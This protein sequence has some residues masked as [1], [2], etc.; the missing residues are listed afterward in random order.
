MKQRH[1]RHF[2]EQNN[3]KSS[4]ALENQQA[5]D[6]AL[7]E[8]GKGNASAHIVLSKWSIF[9]GLDGVNLGNIPRTATWQCD[10]YN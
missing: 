1:T 5:L 10:N 8:N 7:I 2:T 6:P 3:D 4:L 9:Y